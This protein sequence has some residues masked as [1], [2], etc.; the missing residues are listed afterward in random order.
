MKELQI[1]ILTP[2]KLVSKEAGR[3]ALDLLN[4]IYPKFSPERYGSYEPLREVYEPS[5]PEKALEI[6]GKSFLWKRKNPQVEGSIWPAWGPRLTHTW[7]TILIDATKA[8]YGKVTD[9]VQ[10]ASVAFSADFAFTHILTPS[11]ITTGS[12][13]GTVFC[14]DPAKGRY[15]LT[16]T[17]KELAQYIPDIYWATIFGPPY[18]QHFGR[19][20]LLSAPAFIIR[21]LSNG[22]IYLQISKSP[23]DLDTEI[24][25]LSVM[26]QAIKEHLNQNSFFDPAKSAN[27]VYSVPNFHLGLD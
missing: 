10:Q 4:N 12:L 20:K 17:T 6:W 7:I 15:S 27:H 3:K 22:S 21:E 9:F 18:V 1:N 16:V 8:D 2:H 11:D 5:H 26:R 19:A 14:L 24:T 23:L 13:N 25:H